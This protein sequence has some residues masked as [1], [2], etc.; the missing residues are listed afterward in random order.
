M[1]KKKKTKKR[2]S[3]SESATLFPVGK[4]KKGND[5]KMWIVK[6]NIKNSFIFIAL[7]YLPRLKN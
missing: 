6:S 5:D 1:V 4:K 3:P 2:P 7:E